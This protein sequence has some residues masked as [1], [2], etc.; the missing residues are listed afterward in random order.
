MDVGSTDRN[1][2][3]TLNRKPISRALRTTRRSWIPCGHYSPG[4]RSSSW[5]QLW[6]CSSPFFSAVTL[7][8]TILNSTFFLDGSP[9]SMEAGN[10]VSPLGSLG[11]LGI[12]RSA[13]PVL[14]TRV[15]D[16]GGGSGGAVALEIG[17]RRLHVDRAWRFWSVDVCAGTPLAAR[18]RCC[19]CRGV[20]RGESLLHRDCLLEERICRALGRSS[21]AVASLDLFTRPRRRIKGDCPARAHRVCGLA[22]QCAV[23][24]DGELLAG[25][26]SGCG[27]SG[28]EVAP[29]L[30]FR[31]RCGRTRR[32]PGSLLPGACGL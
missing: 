20:I 16:S 8:D 7:L 27:R 5:S 26:A 28:L 21:A 13:F 3:D 4:A 25:P 12:R 32:G 15:M 11:A 6:P 2:T 17:A 30:A 24:G 19:V 29:H 9:Q 14:S 10:L 31:R 23:R 18:A 1:Q 22:Y